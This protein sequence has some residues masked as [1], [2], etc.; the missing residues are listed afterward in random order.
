MDFKIAN[1]IVSDVYSGI[2]GFKISDEAI[3]KS[4]YFYTGMIYDEVTNE[5]FYQI[6]KNIK[7]PEQKVF[8]DLGSGVGKKVF[9][10][11][12][13]FSFK[14]S[15]GIELL[16]DVYNASENAKEIYLDKIK[17]SSAI[18]IPEND[19]EFINADFN[20]CDLSIGNVF[21]ISMSK[22]AMEIELTGMLLHKLECL[23]NGTEVITT[24]IPINSPFFKITGQDI[25]QFSASE[26]NVFF[27]KRIV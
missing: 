24:G 16:Q 4:A 27:H 2:D 5:S 26:G 13:C 3:K 17:S 10:A 8:I 22:A 7:N 25:C 15:I 6:I 21:Y 12:L 20:K 11:S 14:K 9:L 18:N 19:F 1:K 23:E